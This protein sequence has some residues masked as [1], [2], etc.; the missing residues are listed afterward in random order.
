MFITGFNLFLSSSFASELPWS[1]CNHTWADSN[2]V[3]QISRVASNQS[4]SNTSQSPAHQ[5]FE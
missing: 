5:F 2:C 1:H 3:D 4:F